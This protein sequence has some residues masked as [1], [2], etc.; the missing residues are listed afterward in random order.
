MFKD[1]S[2]TLW[3]IKTSLANLIFRPMRELFKWMSSSA[4]MMGV[5]LILNTLNVEVGKHADNVSRMETSWVLSLA[6]QKTNKTLIWP[7]GTLS[8]HKYF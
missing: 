5:F 1:K 6:T 8:S 7:L 3:F 2:Q 4:G